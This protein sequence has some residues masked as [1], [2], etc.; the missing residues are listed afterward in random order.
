MTRRL[1]FL[2]C[3]LLATSAVA[4]KPRAPEGTWS[5]ARC[6]ARGYERRITF[7]ADGTFTAQDRVSPCPENVVCVWS[8]VINRGG[9]YTLKG[10]T[11]RLKAEAPAPGVTVADLPASMSWKKGVLAEPQAGRACTYRPFRQ[12]VP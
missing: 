3:A 9:T 5:S 6:G 11:L 1:S 10:T 4:A 2:C 8:G 12:P 7:A